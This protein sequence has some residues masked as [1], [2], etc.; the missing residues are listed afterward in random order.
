[1]PAARVL[2]HDDEPASGGLNRVDAGPHRLGSDI[3]AVGG[4]RQQHGPG[5]VAFRSE[6]VGS[7]DHAIPHHGGNV[8]LDLHLH[9]RAAQSSRNSVRRTLPDGV[10]GK[11]AVKTTRLG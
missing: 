6:D 3:L 4:S 9:A 2:D 8:E 5:A 7:Q 11:L 10:R 1:M